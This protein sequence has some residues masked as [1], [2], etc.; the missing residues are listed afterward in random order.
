VPALGLGL[1]RHTARGKPAR[2]VA[3]PLGNGG[4]PLLVSKDRPLGVL[5]EAG[6][7]YRADSEN[8]LPWNPPRRVKP[9]QGRKN[10]GSHNRPNPAC[11]TS[12][13][14]EARTPFPSKTTS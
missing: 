14:E 1:T 3:R 4:G 12:G 9:F 7:G 6:R 10:R 13:I 8:R 11:D 5:Q 2:H